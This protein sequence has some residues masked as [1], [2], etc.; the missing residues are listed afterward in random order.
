MPKGL[1]RTGQGHGPGALPLHP[2]KDSRPWNL[3]ERGAAPLALLR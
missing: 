2:A 1:H 3:F